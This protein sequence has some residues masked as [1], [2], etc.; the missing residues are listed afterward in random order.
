MLQAKEKQSRTSLLSL[1]RLHECYPHC[2]WIAEKL[3]SAKQELV[4]LLEK[5]EKFQYH[6]RATNW[7]QMG[8]K[9]TSEFFQA[10]RPNH[11]VV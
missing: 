1:Q 8:D 5:R 3:G 7:T 4:L 6:H 9:C 11:N 10:I 2:T